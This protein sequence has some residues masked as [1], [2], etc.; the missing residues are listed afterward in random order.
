MERSVCRGIDPPVGASG[1]R[2]RVLIVTQYFHPESFLVN[3]LA[4]ALGEGGHEVTVLTGQPSYPTRGQYPGYRAFSPARERYEGVDVV[5][6]PLLSRGGGRLW[7]LALN[8]LSFVVSAVAFG[9]PRL[10]RRFDVSIVW[11]TSPITA[12]IPAM[13]QRAHRGTPTAIWV[14]DLWP[15]TV[16]AI[17]RS[18]NRLLLAGLRRLV[19]RIYRSSDQIWIQSPAFEASVL[20]HGGAPGK[21][22]HVPNWADDLYDR[23]RWVDVQPEPL[24]A[25]ALVFAGN[26]GRAQGLETMVEAAAIV[27]D[28]VPEA[29][30]VFVGDGT[31]REWLIEEI[32]R[33]GLS[34]RI[35]VLPRRPARQM[36]QVLEA[37]AATLVSLA[38]DPV[39]DLTVPSKIPTLLAAGR[40]VL[41]ALSG[42]A[43]R[44]VR[45]AGAGLVCPPGDARGL[46]DIVVRFFEMPAAERERLGRNGH[47][48]YKAHFTEAGVMRSINRLLTSLAADAV[49]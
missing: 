25:N 28:I 12:A 10:R 29:H 48:Y 39:F 19:R 40:P 3:R 4:S 17:T 47:A 21:I 22:V 5:R 36:P 13:V 33:R 34:S 42:E 15:D 49:E 2:I 41:G 30:W 14:Q 27:A 26:L 6:V 20:A 38:D 44:V 23:E 9:L 8:Y 16:E 1:G 11:C 35:S 7:R 37:S 43:A 24:P 31:L 18:K 45:E 32:E 46:A